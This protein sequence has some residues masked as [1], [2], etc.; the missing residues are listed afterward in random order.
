MN[1]A[2]KILEK[3]LSERQTDI[4]EKRFDEIMEIHDALS[5][6]RQYQKYKDLNTQK[7]CVCGK[8]GTL[9]QNETGIYCKKHYGN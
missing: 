9:Y 4:S 1:A 3:E 5:I 6:L 8:T 7:C 2:I